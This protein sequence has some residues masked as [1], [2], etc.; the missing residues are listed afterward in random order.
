MTKVQ[1]TKLREAIDEL[2]DYFEADIWYAS[3]NEWVSQRQA[4]EYIRRHFAVLRKQIKCE[5]IT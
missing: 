4:A 5:K 2:Q 1:L 3:R